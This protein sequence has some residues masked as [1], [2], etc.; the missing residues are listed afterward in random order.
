MK[1]YKIFRSF[2]RV[3]RDVN[4]HVLIGV[5]SGKDIDAVAG[6]II[7]IVSDD[8]LSLPK[9]KSG[10]TSYAYAPEP[11]GDLRRVKRYAYFMDAVAAPEY[12]DHNDIIEYGIIESAEEL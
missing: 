7:K 9:Y 6:R 1:K 5:E 10:Y 11:V 4:K 12:G 2:G 8:V 3:D